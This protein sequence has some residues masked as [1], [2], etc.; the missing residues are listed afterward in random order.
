MHTNTKVAENAHKKVVFVWFRKFYASCIFAQYRKIC[1]KLQR[2]KSRSCLHYK[3]HLIISL[4][5]NDFVTFLTVTV[6][7]HCQFWQSVNSDIV[8]DSHCRSDI[9]RCQSLCHQKSSTLIVSDIGI[10][11]ESVCMFCAQSKNL[12]TC[13]NQCPHTHYISR[14]DNRILCPLPNKGRLFRA[15]RPKHYQC[16]IDVILSSICTQLLPLMQF[17]QKCNVLYDMLH[18]NNHMDMSSGQGVRY[19]FSS[20]GL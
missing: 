12:I 13:K 14:S 9:W 2:W 5:W 3:C 20:T 15:S 7:R 6:A 4:N 19:C 11:I 1:I 17:L 18:T 16:K 8:I 10:Y